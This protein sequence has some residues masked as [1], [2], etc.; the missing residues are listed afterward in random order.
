M[1]RP[2]TPSTSGAAEWPQWSLPTSAWSCHK[3]V[4]VFHGERDK[5]KLTVIRWCNCMDG[6]RDALAWSDEATYTKASAALFGSAQR[7]ADNWAVL[8]KATHQKT[9]TYL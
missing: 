7:K 6:L 8:Y 5:D 3:K 1:N 9:C 2:A 4:P